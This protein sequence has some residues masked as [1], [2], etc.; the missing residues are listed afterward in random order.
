MNQLIKYL[1]APIILGKKYGN[2]HG[3]M[4]RNLIHMY[5]VCTRKVDFHNLDH[6]A[7]MEIRKANLA[8]CNLGIHMTRL[9]PFHIKDEH[10]NC[11]FKTASYT[12][13]EKIDDSDL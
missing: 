3:T 2:V 13:G 1:Y 8:G 11:V 7:C 10:A 6:L 9:N 12:L 5:D 4:L